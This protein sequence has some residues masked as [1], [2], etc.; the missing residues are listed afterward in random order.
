MSAKHNLSNLVTFFATVVFSVAQAFT[1]QAAEEFT[2]PFTFVGIPDTQID[3]LLYPQR[4]QS[5][6]TWILDNQTNEN[7]A[8]VAQHGD[9]V[10]T[11]SWPASESEWIV[12]RDQFFRLNVDGGPAWGTAAGNHDTFTASNQARY[13][14]Y[15][16][17][18]HFTGKS[19]YGGA[20]GLS[21][22][23]IFEASGREYLVLDLEDQVIP[24]SGIPPSV[25]T[26]AQDVI[27]ANPGKPIIVNTHDY[28]T[29]N[30]G[31]GRSAVGEALWNNLVKSN[32]RIFMV[33]SAHLSGNIRMDV[34]S[35]DAGQEVYEI[36][37]LYDG[38]LPVM[39]PTLLDGGR[40]GRMRLYDFDEVHSVIRV[41]SFSPFHTT[42]PYLTDAANQFDIP[43][44]FNE[45]LGPST[46]SA[47]AFTWSDGN[48]GDWAAPSNWGSVVTSA[49]HGNNN[50]V[51]FGPAITA[52]RTVFTDTAVTVR[53]IQFDNADTFAIIGTGS[54][55]L[56]ADAGN[57]S[58]DVV[59]GNHQFQA[60]VNLNSN[61]DVNVAAG[62]SLTFINALNLGGNTLTKT[63]AGEMFINNLLNT[64][65]GSV[66]A[67]AGVLA[68]GGTIGGDL[69]NIGATV[70]PG[71]SAGTLT[72]IGDYTQAIGSLAVE[73]NGSA[74]GEFDVLK[75]TGNLNISGGTLD[76]AF[77]AMPGKFKILDVSGTSSV[78]F[79]SLNNTGGLDVRLDGSLLASSGELTV[80]SALLG[81]MDGDL[82][83][84]AADASLL[85]QALVDRAGYD[86][87]GFFIVGAEFNGD[88][89]GSSTFDLDD[90]AAFNTLLSATSTVPEPGSASLL[91]LAFSALSLL[92]NRSKKRELTV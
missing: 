26:W 61:T 37:A 53:H 75:V 56:A 64:G 47:F 92:G 43:M 30:P 16:G 14:F 60:I 51:L 38:G 12:A 79:A 69:A 19:W 78:A 88:V 31:P 80:L 76:V 8:F 35:N 81:D 55:N 7:I 59:Q 87:N 86:A 1:A 33:L 40:N 15:F 39:D 46:V 89:D 52:P 5:V 48:G 2:I 34:S 20:F 84:T 44:N 67:S 36:M 58:I 63:G 42:Q 24:P 71:N 13:D 45:R 49:P 10:D 66:L 4:L 62:S 29:N 21:S 22:Y 6:I 17:P 25:F 3:T 73:I 85:A 23:Q 11:T 50:A 57:A 9:L 65:G 70:A 82:A 68:G 91:I 32:P 27:D 72:V 77:A 18:Q 74:E 83:I 54:V 41:T 90:M 28:L